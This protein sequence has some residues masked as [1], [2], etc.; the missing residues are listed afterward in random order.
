MTDE[1]MAE[2]ALQKRLGTYGYISYQD[3]HKNYTDGFKDGYNKANEWHK[4][5]DGDYPKHNN[6]VLCLLW[7]GIKEIGC[8]KNGLWY[9]E[10]FTADK[11]DVDYWQEIIL[12]KEIKENEL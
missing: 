7:G 11:D 8:Y 4:V 9:F 6:E 10:D 3:C 12:P 5:L 1:E 2:E